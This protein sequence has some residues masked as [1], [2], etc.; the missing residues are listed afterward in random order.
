G[1]QWAKEKVPTLAEALEDIP[2]GKRVL[3][4]IKCSSEVLPELARVLAASGKPPE[5]LVI[6]GFDYATMALAR[7]LLPR[8]EVYWVVGHKPPRG[9]KEPPSLSELAQK[10]RRA[11]F[12]GL[13]LNY[14]FPLDEAAVA[15]LKQQGLKVLVWTVDEAPVAARLAAAGVDGI[16]TNRPQWIREQLAHA[17]GH[18]AGSIRTIAGTGRASDGG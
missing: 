2:A 8:H 7:R 4:E 10:A 18:E 16:T 5:Q 12:T 11:G 15:Q 9:S 6:I 13:D 3:I 1:Q 14:E 17:A